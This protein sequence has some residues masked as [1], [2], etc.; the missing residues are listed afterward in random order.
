MRL[1][2]AQIETHFL[3][4]RTA[5]HFPRTVSRLRR[6]FAAR[7][8]DIVQT[9]LFHAN[10]IGALA[11][12]VCRQTKFITG[13]R[14][15]DPRRWRQRIERQ[16]SG[17]AKRVVC[18]SQDVAMY[19][20]NDVGLPEEK[21]VVIPNGVDCER[22]A[23]AAPANLAQFGVP[24]GR[25]VFATV[26][27]LDRQKGFDWLLP[28]TPQLLNGLPDHDWLLIG[29][30]EQRAELEQLA[31][32]TGHRERIHF[33]GWQP[34]IP[35]ILRSCEAVLL[36]SRWEGM[37]NVL[38]EAMATGLPVVATRVSGVEEI[39]G[40]LAGEQS[41][42]LG[43]KAGFLRRVRDLLRD[44]PRCERLGR[45]NRRRVER[46]FSLQQMVARYQSLFELLLPHEEPVGM[47]RERPKP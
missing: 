28:L 46:E 4:G 35:G 14:V 37:P 32:A 30:G 20:R 15:A 42:A 39:L 17:S 8:P 26:G 44:P 33:A 43:D 22:C 7:P 18:V 6:H 11:A 13:F 9:F 19:C 10:V 34:E 40:P 36:P 23:Q 21:L 2:Q 31:Q 47:G 45:E 1:E 41:V 24:N 12:R 5:V 3:D 29:D 25:R 27:R 16:A 38:L